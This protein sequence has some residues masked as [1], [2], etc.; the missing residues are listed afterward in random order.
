MVPSCEMLDAFWTKAVHVINGQVIDGM[1]DGL[2]GNSLIDRASDTIN[3]GNDVLME[4][5]WQVETDNG[6][7]N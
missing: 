4:L 2:I 6:E 7:V 5:K 3:D 1:N